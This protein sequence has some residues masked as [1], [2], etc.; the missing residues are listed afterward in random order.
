MPSPLDRRPRPTRT[1]AR[2]AYRSR[3]GAT[4]LP[5]TTLAGEQPVQQATVGVVRWSSVG[6][7]GSTPDERSIP[8][9]CDGLVATPHVVAWRAVDVVASAPLLF[10]WVCQLR[11]APYSYDLIDNLGRR[12]PRRL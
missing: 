5:L 9:G 7:W 8:F 10:R 3:H 11:V 4:P 6:T 2:P 1:R 12:S